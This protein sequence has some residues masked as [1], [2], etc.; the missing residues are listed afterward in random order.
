MG[1]LNDQMNRNWEGFRIPKGKM[2]KR[3]PVVLSRQECEAFCAGVGEA[4][5]RIRPGG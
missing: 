1:R 4:L 3:P 5:S 2:G